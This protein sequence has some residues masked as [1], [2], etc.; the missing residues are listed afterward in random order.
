MKLVF[1]PDARWELWQA[2]EY[3]DRLSE[4][5]GDRFVDGVYAATREIGEAPRSWPI[6]K[7]TVPIRLVKN[8]PYGVYDRI[9]KQCV[10][11]L[12]VAHHSRAKRFG[13]KY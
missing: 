9:E 5:L 2:T 3:Y 8:F 11:I 13:T 10:R 7:G 1:N 12:S 6:F 4:S